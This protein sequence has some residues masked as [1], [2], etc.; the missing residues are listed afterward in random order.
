MTATQLTYERLNVPDQS[1]TTHD[2]HRRE[3]RDAE[4]TGD[5]HQLPGISD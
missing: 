2:R 5:W 3:P 1:A 4:T